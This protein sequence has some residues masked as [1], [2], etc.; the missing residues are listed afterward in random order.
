MRGGP[1]GDL[2]V[3]V[4]VRPHKLFRREGSTL[5]LDF[6][7]SFTQA[8]LGSEVDIPTLHGS[9]KYK[10]PEGT[11]TDTEFRIRGQGIPILRTKN[12]GDLVFRVRVETPRR[13]N[14]RQKE[15]LRQFE[16]SATGREYEGKKSFMDK[17][18]NAF[19]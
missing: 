14:D 4:G 2:F 11:Q 18:K 12:N 5:L 13:L 1:S 16:S 8:A 3:T 17:L 6:P 19:S 15:L 10:I 7:I 9:V